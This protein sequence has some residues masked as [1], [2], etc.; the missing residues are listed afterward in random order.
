MGECV[1]LCVD[2]HELMMCVHLFL[3][4]CGRPHLIELTAVAMCL[5]LCYRLALYV[6]RRLYSFLF[7]HICIYVFYVQVVGVYRA[8]ASAK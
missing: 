4:V 3:D 6:L 5:V 1:G 7:G 8:N 2:S